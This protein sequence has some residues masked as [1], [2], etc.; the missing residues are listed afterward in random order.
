MNPNNV[1]PFA[2]LLVAFWL[3]IIRPSQRQKAARAAIM[4]S[5]KP[6]SDV[7]TSGGIQGLVVALEDDVVVLEIASGVH[8]RFM[9]SAVA[10]VKATP[11][12]DPTASDGAADGAG[13]IDT[14]DPSEP[15]T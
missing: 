5:L 7:V 6:G 9:R 12:D 14:K 4:A 10:A 11:E 1:L 13:I 15:T 3:L 2:L 8:V